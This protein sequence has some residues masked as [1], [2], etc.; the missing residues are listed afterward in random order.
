MNVV[1]CQA[2]SLIKIETFS[3][4]SAVGGYILKGLT[5]TELQKTLGSN[6][7]HNSTCTGD[8]CNKVTQLQGFGV[9]LL[10]VFL[11]VLVVLAATDDKRESKVMWRF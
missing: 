11:L 1:D 3:H 8:D 6:A 4:S 9:E 7:L 10:T 5:P 2:N